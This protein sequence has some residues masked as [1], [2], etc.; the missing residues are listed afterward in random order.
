MLWERQGFNGMR[1]RP[2]FAQVFAMDITLSFFTAY[3]D[4][5]VLI[6]DH[7]MIAKH[8]L[9]CVHPTGIAG[10]AMEDRPPLL[11]APTVCAAHRSGSV[12]RDAAEVQSQVRQSRCAM[13]TWLVCNALVTLCNILHCDRFRF[14]VDIIAW[15]P[16]DY[17][18]VEATWPPC[19]TSNAARYVSLLKLLR[20]VRRFDACTLSEACCTALVPV[21]VS[22]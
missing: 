14:W 18:I 7:K 5:E 10:V 17:I 3:Y 13:Y 6:T 1:W 20:C 22:R 19:Y 8:Y 9:K 21:S 4:Q 15:F 12:C 16:F 11:R 2:G